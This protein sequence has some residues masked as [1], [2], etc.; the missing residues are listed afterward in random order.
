MHKVR[1]LYYF[2][3]IIAPNQNKITN[4]LGFFCWIQCDIWRVMKII[5]W[6][7]SVF[8]KWQMDCYTSMNSI[9]KPY[10][11]VELCLKKQYVLKWKELP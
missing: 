3:Q 10:P 9:P 4:T 1:F 6:N 5:I 11:V 8:G 7:D 2:F